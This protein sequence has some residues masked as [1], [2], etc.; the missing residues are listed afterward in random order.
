[1]KTFLITIP[2]QRNDK[3]LA[4]IA[5]PRF[6]TAGHKQSFEREHPQVTQMWPHSLPGACLGISNAMVIATM[7]PIIVQGTIHTPVDFCW[8][9]T[10]WFTTGAQTDGMKVSDSLSD[11]ACSLSY[12]FGIG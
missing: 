12:I 3:Y 8:T 6:F 1:M 9:L 4:N 7:A 2:D 11:V 5:K 10:G